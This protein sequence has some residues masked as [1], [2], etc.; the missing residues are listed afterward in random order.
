MGPCTLETQLLGRRARHL[1]RD[2]I[3]ESCAEGGGGDGVGEGMNIIT[4]VDVDE[5]EGGGGGRGSGVV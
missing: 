2:N 4:S 1:Q 5:E 3:A